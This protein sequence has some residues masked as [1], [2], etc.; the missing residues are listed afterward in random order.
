MSPPLLMV[1][2]G[3][4]GAGK[5]TLARVLAPRLAATIVD[6]DAIRARCCPGAPADAR[7]NAIANAE[8]VREIGQ[9]LRSGESVI[10]DGRTYAADADRCRMAEMG[11]AAG[12]RVRFV[13]LDVSLTLAKQRVAQS[14]GAHPA[15]DRTA[16]L[17]HEVA[18]RF[19][20]V[21]DRAL[22]LDGS[23]SIAALADDVLL[24]LA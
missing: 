5:T 10:A 17:V 24:W 16:R 18:R 12:A 11:L 19:D 21:E 22:H 3:L 14:R 4:P 15:S 20:E 1:L 6:R 7:S 23:R 2:I 9:R 8:M 13:W